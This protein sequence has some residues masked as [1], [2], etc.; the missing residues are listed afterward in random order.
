M[1][2]VLLAYVLIGGLMMPLKMGITGV[3]AGLSDSLHIASGARSTLFI[4]IYNPG[5]K[6]KADEVLLVNGSK[7]FKA[8]NV[9][10]SD[11][12]VLAADFTPQ[13]GKN[14]ASETMYNLFVHA[15]GHWMGFPN[16]MGIK[17]GASDTAKANDVEL[18]REQIEGN[19]DKLKG[20]P[21][22]IILYESIRNLLYHVPMWFSMIFILS[23]SA[24]YAIKFLNKGTLDFDMRSSALVQ[25]GILAGI[26]G[27]LTGSVWASVTW[28]AWWP[29]DPKL[30]GVAI[31]MLMYLGYLL[32]RN[33][34]KDEYQKAR[35]SAV[36]N[37]FIF[38]I[39]IA[40]IAIM[41]RLSGESLHPGAGGTVTFK[42]YDLDN[43][44]RMYF[45]PAVIGWICLFAW[46]ASLLYRYKKLKL[47]WSDHG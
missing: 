25:T 17:M 47:Q 34:I 33:G 14:G 23:L 39:F 46:L 22:R 15:N 7:V 31:G 40:L 27:C 21:N 4:D 6:F 28:E 38:P 30:N 3:H 11:S 19:P 29:R 26:L 5:E 32:L 8:E 10:W 12:S 1:G 44:L 18:N 9:V 13:F 43:T 36:Y 41:P 35:V 16:A 2:I 37:L 45:Y 24:W 42:Q 20:F